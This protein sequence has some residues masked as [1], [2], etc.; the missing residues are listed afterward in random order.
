MRGRHGAERR[1]SGPCDHFS[2]PPL[3]FG[4]RAGESSKSPCSTDAYSETQLTAENRTMKAQEHKTESYSDLNDRRTLLGPLDV[5]AKL[6]I[7][8]KA[9]HMFVREGKLACVQVSARV[10]RFTEEQVQEFIQSQ[11]IPRRVDKK[12]RR[13]LSSPLMKGGDKKS[14][15]LSR[16]DLRKEI[17]SWR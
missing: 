4:L 12:P 13:P 14:V 10:R 3:G 9:V 2:A 5:A 8:V 6:N 11:S 16:T 1:N 17:R 15:G 7:P